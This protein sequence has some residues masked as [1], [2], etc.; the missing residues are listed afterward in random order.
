[1]HT[2]IIACLSRD[3]A[4]KGFA[5]SKL[6]RA[7]FKAMTLAYNPPDLFESLRKELEDGISLDALYGS[8]RW[9]GE[10]G[11]IKGVS[12]AVLVGRRTWEEA[13]PWG[14]AGKELPGRNVYLLSAGYKEELIGYY[15]RADS[16]DEAIDC[17]ARDGAPV[18]WIAGGAQVYQ[19]ALVHPAV[20]RAYLTEVDVESKEATAWWPYT[21]ESGEVMF[22]HEG[23]GD[24]P[25]WHRT[26]ATPWLMETDGRRVRFTQWERQP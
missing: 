19:Q 1:M 6:D 17:A 18:L 9:I 12:N 20:T 8:L 16:L 7:F 2:A 4:L 10:H 23:S 21:I 11:S 14:M 13:E 26:A 3:G 25:E 15:I 22:D 5:P 24:T